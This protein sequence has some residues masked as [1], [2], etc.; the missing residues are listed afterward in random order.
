MSA[1]S[2]IVELRVA[3][4]GPALPVMRVVMGGMASRHDVPLEKL[5]DVQLAVET[6]LREESDAGGDL[7]LCVSVQAGS[8]VIRLEGLT[9]PSL[10]AALLASEP[11]QPCEGCLLDVRLFLDSLVDSYAVVEG[12]SGRFTV[13]MKKRA[14]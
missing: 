7:A 12:S 14:R 9:N 6:L 11:F 3:R 8:F 4:G 13:E 10:K 5:D 2:D 1:S